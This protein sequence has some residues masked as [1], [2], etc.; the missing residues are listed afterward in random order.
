LFTIPRWACCIPRWGCYIRR[1]NSGCTN[2]VQ[3]D[4]S[5]ERRPDLVADDRTESGEIRKDRQTMKRESKSE[6][7]KSGN[8]EAS[9]ISYIK[10]EKK[11]AI[12]VNLI[13]TLTVQ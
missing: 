13:D 5:G 1:S 6:A 8:G 9:K 4:C 2:F 12:C 7:K 3:V 10:E 11:L